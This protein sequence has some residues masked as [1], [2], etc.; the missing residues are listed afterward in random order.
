M[1]FSRFPLI[2]C[3][4]FVADSLESQLHVFIFFVWPAFVHCYVW[5]LCLSPSAASK[6][7][8]AAQ[9]LLLATLHS[10]YVGQSSCLPDVFRHAGISNCNSVF[11]V[12]FWG[13]WCSAF[14]SGFEIWRIWMHHGFWFFP[15]FAQVS[16]M[17]CRSLEWIYGRAHLARGFSSSL[18]SQHRRW[19]DRYD[20]GGT[21]QA[22][23]NLKAWFSSAK[24]ETLRQLEMEENN[25][26]IVHVLFFWLRQ[27]GWAVFWFLCL[28]SFLLLLWLWLWSSS[29]VVAVPCFL[30]Q[31]AK[32]SKRRLDI[33][34]MT[35][36]NNI[37]V[38]GC[39]HSLF[40][41][42]STYIHKMNISISHSNW[43][44]PC[45]YDFCQYST[46]QTASCYRFPS[47]RNRSVRRSTGR[48]STDS[49]HSIL[50]SYRFALDRELVQM[51]SS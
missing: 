39:T 41:Y 3:F 28:F 11:F 51:R 22:G 44:H 43:F 14:A 7:F 21:W 20:L 38:P 30:S 10:C 4:H 42:S 37:W 8:I 36:S 33:N 49:D 27:L 34:N 2:R 46:F 12:S 35:Y 26:C 16:Q 25:F 18:K 1:L 40:Y 19:L 50:R 13:M 45:L 24:R 9:I 48:V 29:L 17:F 31:V 6:V 47:P 15:Y 23:S 32:L 5:F